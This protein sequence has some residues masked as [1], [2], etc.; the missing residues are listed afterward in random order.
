M[1]AVL[2]NKDQRLFIYCTDTGSEMSKR[3][4]TANLARHWHLM[5]SPE[6]GAGR[7]LLSSTVKG[8]WARQPAALGIPVGGTGFFQPLA[9]WPGTF[10][11]SF[12]P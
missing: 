11:P 8:T 12:I 9:W 2:P 1:N 6:V 5:E 7:V 3:S 4:L 10:C